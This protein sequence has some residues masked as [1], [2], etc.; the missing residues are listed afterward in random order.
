MTSP[1]LMIDGT[2]V[3]SFDAVPGMT[4]R[5]LSVKALSPKGKFATL[6][7]APVTPGIVSLDA[8][9]TPLDISQSI[10]TSKSGRKVTLKD[11]EITEACQHELQLEQAGSNP[12]FARIKTKLRMPKG[13]GVVTDEPAPEPE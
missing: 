8:C 6:W 10:T 12:G 5:K 4:L 2:A 7:T 13:K 9:G 11:V 3:T 1:A